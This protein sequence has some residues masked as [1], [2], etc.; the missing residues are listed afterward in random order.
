MPSMD[1]SWWDGNIRKSIVFVASQN[2]QGLNKIPKFHFPYELAKWKLTSVH[3]SVKKRE[4][5]K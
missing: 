5:L 2:Q 1:N 3:S 4:E